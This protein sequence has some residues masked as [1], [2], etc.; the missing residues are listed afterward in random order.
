V[1]RRRPHHR[2][3]RRI[4]PCDRIG[5]QPLRLTRRIVDHDDRG[6]QLRID[7]DDDLRVPAPRCR[8]LREPS[9]AAAE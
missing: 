9:P 6:H 8:D 3:G 1:L 5:E 2:L 4:A 7:V